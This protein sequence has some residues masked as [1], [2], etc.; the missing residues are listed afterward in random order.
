MASQSANCNLTPPCTAHCSGWLSSSCGLSNICRAQCSSPFLWSPLSSLLPHLCNAGSSTLNLATGFAFRAGW[1]QHHLGAVFFSL[2]Q[3]SSLADCPAMS[4]LF[5]YWQIKIQMQISWVRRPIQLLYAF[6]QNNSCHKKLHKNV[7]KPRFTF[8]YNT[9]KNNFHKSR[10]T[11][12]TSKTFFRSFAVAEWRT[13]CIGI[14]DVSSIFKNEINLDI[15][16]QFCCNYC[17]QKLKLGRPFVPSTGLLILSAG[18]VVP[19]TKKL[20]KTTELLLAPQGVL[21]GAF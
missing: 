2:S 9:T 13:L 8:S 5:V 18:T 16:S 1:R 21:R 14:E 6:Q 19:P 12:Q 20:N 11:K 4:F 15:L 7:P 17:K 3:V 10:N